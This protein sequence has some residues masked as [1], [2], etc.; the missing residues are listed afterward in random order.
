ANTEKTGNRHIL[1]AGVACEISR[2]ATAAFKISNILDD[3]SVEFEDKSDWG[4][5]WYPVPGRT[6]RVS[7]QMKF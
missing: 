7:L 4:S 3:D 2:F 1:D 6:Y 5:F